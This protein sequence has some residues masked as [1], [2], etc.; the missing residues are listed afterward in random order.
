MAIGVFQDDD[1]VIHHDADREGQGQEREIV[2]RE[3]QRVHHGE[4]RN[5]GGR[6][7]KAGNDRRAE[8]PEEKENDDDD[9]NAGDHQGGFSLLDGASTKTDWSKATSSLTPGEGPRIAGSSF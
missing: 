7:G 6:D 8:I 1:G 2:D 4:G 9:Q 5:D 3:A